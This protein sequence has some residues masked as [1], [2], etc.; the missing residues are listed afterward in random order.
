MDG[1][2]ADRMFVWLEP[3]HPDRRISAHEAGHRP[4]RFVGLVGG[5]ARNSARLGTERTRCLVRSQRSSGASLAAL[6]GGA[7]VDLQRR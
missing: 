3:G 2:A 5:A 4:A 1:L 7:G 6:A